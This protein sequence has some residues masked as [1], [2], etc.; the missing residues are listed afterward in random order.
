MKRIFLIVILA[1]QVASLSY[2]AIDSA[3]NE[4]VYRGGA[5]VNNIEKNGDVGVGIML[6]TTPGITGKVWLSETEAVQVGL[7]LQSTNTA[8]IAD[9]IWNWRDAFRSLSNSSFAKS[10]VPYIGLGGIG[11]WGGNT[12]F[13]NR[14]TGTFGFG[15]RLPVGLEYLPRFLPVGV[16]AEI[17]PGFGVAPTT[18]SFFQADVGARF[19]F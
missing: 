8:A 13:F 6:G 4:T 5:A 12:A 19:Y 3:P 9:Y 11:V 1:T 10:L 2:G 17:D 18:F 15:F 14:D 16:F 7:G